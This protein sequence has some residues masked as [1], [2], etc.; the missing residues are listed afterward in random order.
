M[1][2]YETTEEASAFVG[3]M[4]ELDQADNRPVAEFFQHAIA[5]NV[6]GPVQVHSVPSVS[7]G[8]RSW[9]AVPATVGESQRV[10]N[11]D[12]RRRSCTVI[13]IDQN[14]YVAP[15]KQEADAGTCAL[16][17]KLVPLVLTHQDAVYVRAATGTTAVSV[18]S[19]NWAS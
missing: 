12:P 17:P 9:T 19:E 14:I 5:V 13:A 4:E 10:A 16:W 8:M 2:A 18:I 1:P 3:E 6:D 11:I 15:T 7:A